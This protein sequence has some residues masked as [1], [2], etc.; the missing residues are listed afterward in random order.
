M[1]SETEGF[2]PQG[3]SVFSSA[4]GQENGQF[5]RKR[6]F[7]G[8]RFCHKDTKAPRLKPPS[9]LRVFVP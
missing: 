9:F 1:L 7:D 3:G 2:P 4:A 5:N 6:N 8:I